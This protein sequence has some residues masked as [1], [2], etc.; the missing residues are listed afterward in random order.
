MNKRGKPKH[1]R[2]ANF[3]DEIS[4]GHI[5]HSGIFLKREA[6]AQ[7]RK[8][9]GSQTLGFLELSQRGGR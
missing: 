8:Q 7:R 2:T 3:T 4:E 1:Q 5:W 9:D 6:D